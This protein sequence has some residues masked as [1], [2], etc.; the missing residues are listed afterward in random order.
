MKAAFLDFATVGSDELDDSPLRMLT[1]SFEVFDN[2]AADEIAE[3]IADTEFVYV[4]KI[5]MTR[6][7]IEQSPDLRFIGL[8][9]TGT[10]NV[11][12]EAAKEHDV[13]VCN[14][15]AYCT[16]SVVDTMP[17]HTWSPWPRCRSCSLDTPANR[18]SPSR[19]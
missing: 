12:L 10:D 16:N 18:S 4:N 5:R 7:I 11:D 9:A 8:V 2:T 13:A 17:R 14:I 6:D 15:R 1:D 19:G 3:R